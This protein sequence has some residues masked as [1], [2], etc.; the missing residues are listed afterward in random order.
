MDVVLVGG[1][2]PRVITYLLLFPTAF[3][4]ATT[5]LSTRRRQCLGENDIAVIR[6]VIPSIDMWVGQGSSDLNTTSIPS[7]WLSHLS[8]LSPS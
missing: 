1:R 6:T 3:P 7:L 8:Q 5:G 4:T 2:A